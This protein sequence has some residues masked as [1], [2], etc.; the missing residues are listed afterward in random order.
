MDTI[1]QRLRQALRQ[2]G[3][4]QQELAHRVGLTQSAVKHWLA[5]NGPP[6][7]RMADVEKALNLPTGTLMGKYDERL[8]PTARSLVHWL[9][10]GAFDEE[11][12]QGFL[13][14]CTKMASLFEDEPPVT[15]TGGRRGGAFRAA[16]H[17]GAKGLRI[18]EPSR[19]FDGRREPGGGVT[20]SLY[21]PGKAAAS[22]GGRDWFDPL[23]EPPTEEVSPNRL[24]WLCPPQPLLRDQH[25]ILEVEGDSMEPVIPQGALCVVRHSEV[26]QAELPNVVAWKEGGDDR[27]AI[28]HLTVTGAEVLLKSRNPSHPP[29]LLNAAHQPR[30]RGHVVAVVR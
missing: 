11:E 26:P 3:L 1:A 6:A 8:P 23:D 18:A 4:T 15:R 16:G 20:V 21:R 24:H 25:Y 29:L 22:T 2:S 27:V 13:K 7:G 28:K 17:G 10:E 14:V 12:L 9:E 5:H 19:P 30:V